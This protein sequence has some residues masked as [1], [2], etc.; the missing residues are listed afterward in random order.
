MVPGHGGQC[1]HWQE[2]GISI[3]LYIACLATQCRYDADAAWLYSSSGIPGQILSTEIRS[4]DEHLGT[5]LG[6]GTKGKNSGPALQ[7]FT[8][9]SW[10][11]MTTTNWLLV[12]ACLCC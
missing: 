5:K 7:Q 11:T 12:A 6:M 10:V 3:G 1:A 4:G 2:L 8:S 9:R